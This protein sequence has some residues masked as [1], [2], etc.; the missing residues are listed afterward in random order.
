MSTS[1]HARPLALP[2]AATITAYV[3][4]ILGAIAMAAPFVWMVLTSISEESRVFVYPPRFWPDPITFANYG[5]LFRDAPVRIREEPLAPLA[6]SPVTFTMIE[7][8][9]WLRSYPLRR[10]ADGT[11]SGLSAAVPWILPSGNALGHVRID[12]N[13]RMAAEVADAINARTGWP[14]RRLAEGDARGRP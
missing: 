14:T 1:S 10:R 3:V 5:Q 12:T 8:H 4:V 11:A 7:D 2:T 6:T 9:D 13:A